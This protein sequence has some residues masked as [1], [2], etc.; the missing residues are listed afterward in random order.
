MASKRRFVQ[1]TL[2]LVGFLIIFFTYFS[3]IQKKQNL[4]EVKK[5]KIPQEEFVEENIN[6][7]EDVEYEGIDSS[8]NRFVIGSKYAQF[9]KER[10]EVIHME[11]I[12]CT[13]SFKDKTVLT[14]IADTGIFNNVTNDMNFSD[15]VR[16]DYLQNVLFSDRA[17][18]NNYENQLLVDGNIRGE[19]PQANLEADELDFDLNTKNLKISMYNDERVNI[20]TK[21]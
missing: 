1:L 21:F 15:N 11:E 6:K 16:M 10:P 12:K 5:E 20:K 19:G 17:L 18:F 3:N 14:I 7:F 13:F 2:I 4:K 9:E 8:G